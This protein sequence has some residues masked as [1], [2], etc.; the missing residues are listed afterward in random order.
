MLSSTWFE[1]TYL[2]YIMSAPGD[3]AGILA[4]A[5]EGSA[6]PPIAPGGLRVAPPPGDDAPLPVGQEGVADPGRHDEGADGG[7]RE[8]PPQQIQPGINPRPAGVPL[9]AAATNAPQTTQGTQQPQSGNRPGGDDGGGRT[10]TVQG[11]ERIGDGSD[12]GMP[13][14]ADLDVLINNGSV[15]AFMAFAVLT[16]SEFDKI[17][18]GMGMPSNLHYSIAAQ[19]TPQE[20]EEYLE[21]ATVDGRA[22]K[23]YTKLKVR[24]AFRVMR[25]AAGLPSSCS[26]PPRPTSKPSPSYAPT[27]DSTPSTGIQPGE[28]TG[29]SMVALSDTI[30]QG[31]KLEARMLTEKYLKSARANYRKAEGYDPPNDED[32]TRE[33]LTAL[34]AV[35]FSLNSK[36]ANLEFGCQIGPG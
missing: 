26:M 10:S 16:V 6:T 21:E 4:A 5:A 18:A 3:A 8:Q 32:C 9:R 20:V 12:W 17:F 29:G 33:Q 25:Y 27:Q 23:I 31:S 24:L 34:F 7:E 14:P 11:D 30:E 28:L 22:I 1:V 19:M 35:V 13:E 15:A 2:F 36:K